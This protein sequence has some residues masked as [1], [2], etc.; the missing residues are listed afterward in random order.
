MNGLNW[1]L[2][3][4]LKTVTVTFLS[5]PPVALQLNTVEVDAMLKNLGDFR[6]ARG[7]SNASVDRDDPTTALRPVPTN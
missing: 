6:S 1:K 2:E 3:D 7:G 5:D 4:D